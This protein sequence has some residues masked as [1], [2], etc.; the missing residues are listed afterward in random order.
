MVLTIKI[1][2]YKIYRMSTNNLL[3]ENNYKLY[4]KSTKEGVNIKN[5]SNSEYLTLQ[6]NSI[7][8][9]TLILPSNLNFGVNSVL[10]IQSIIGDEIYLE[11]LP[12]DVTPPDFLTINCEV[13]NASQEVNSKQF[14]LKSETPL[15]EVNTKLIQPN[16]SSSFD[17]ILEFPNDFLQI[18]GREGYAVKLTLDGLEQKLSYVNS[19]PLFTT[20]QT[21]TKEFSLQNNSGQKTIITTSDLQTN[22][23][24]LI[25]PE[26][27]PQN[28]QYLK[29]L[30]A[31][32]LQWASPSGNLGLIAKVWNYSYTVP[33]YFTLQPSDS[34][35]FNFDIDIGTVSP[36]TVYRF[37]LSALFQNKGTATVVYFF[38]ELGNTSGIRLTSTLPVWV[39]GVIN[40]INDSNVQYN[41]HT[42]TAYFYNLSSGLQTLNAYFYSETQGIL[43]HNMELT[44]WDCT[45]HTVGYI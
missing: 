38:M 40:P 15:A 12:C 7:N 42:I 9:Y 34:R 19:L 18:V 41:N 13:L 43:T 30:N 45:I 44:R 2:V 14:Q 5:I 31:N 26:S 20:T 32:Q 1:F 24:N 36:N 3:G 11:W 33:Y 27:P 10:K 29:A 17:V 39:S 6:S 28:L 21:K 22:N 23:I 4:V 35:T 25:L 8:A 37:D 16:G